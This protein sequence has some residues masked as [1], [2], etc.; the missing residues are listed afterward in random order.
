MVTTN[1]KNPKAFADAL[2][3]L[4]DH[5]ENR[6]SMGKNARQLA[7]SKFDREILAKHFVCWLEMAHADFHNLNYMLE[8]HK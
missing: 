2:I 3:D 8:E 6:Y 7:G 1:P 5:P 4:A